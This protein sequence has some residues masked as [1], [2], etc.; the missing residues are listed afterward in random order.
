MD[1]KFLVHTRVGVVQG[2]CAQTLCAGVVREGC[3]RGLCAGLVRRRCAVQG[4]EGDQVGLR[5]TEGD[6][7]GPRGT[8][9]QAGNLHTGIAYWMPSRGRL[10]PDW[11]ICN[12][13]VLARSFRELQGGCLQNH[14]QSKVK[15]W[16]VVRGCAPGLCALC[17]PLAPGEE[18]F[19]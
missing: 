10:I 14:P 15:I 13:R 12:F 19:L 7:G 8:G 6:R 11:F 3:A 2:G 16:G 9:V 1:N 4:T 17:A 18:P 5:G